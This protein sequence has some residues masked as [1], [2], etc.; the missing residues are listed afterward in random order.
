MEKLKYVATSTKFATRNMCAPFLL[1]D[2]E[3]AFLDAICRDGLSPWLRAL[4]PPRGT[5]GIAVTPSP[6]RRQTLVA[7]SGHR[8]TLIAFLPPSGPFGP[9]G[10]PGLSIFIGIVSS[11][12][13]CYLLARYL[14]SPSGSP[15]SSYAAFSGGRPYGQSGWADRPPA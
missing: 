14:T 5:F 4:A 2:K 3:M 15:A 9:G 10:V 7:G 13:V 1:G 8:Y 11:G 6:F 12:L